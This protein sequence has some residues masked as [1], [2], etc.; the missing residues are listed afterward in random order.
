[1]PPLLP[2]VYPVTVPL[3]AS[4]PVVEYA[5]FIKSISDTSLT[6]SSSYV[7]ASPSKYSTPSSSPAITCFVT[8]PSLMLHIPD[9]IPAIIISSSPSTSGIVNDEGALTLFF[10]SF[11][12]SVSPNINTL[13]AV[14]TPTR[15]VPSISCESSGWASLSASDTAIT[16]RNLSSRAFVLGLISTL[17]QPV[18][19]FVSSV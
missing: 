1:M 5:R 14:S 10:K 11:D 2:A 9:F 7:P 16:F 12:V 13:S 18:I 3:V 8:L 6:Y 17:P 19:A 15:F 4:V